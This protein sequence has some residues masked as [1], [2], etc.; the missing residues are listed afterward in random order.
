MALDLGTS[1]ACVMKIPACIS[2]TGKSRL[3]WCKTQCGGSEVLFVFRRSLSRE[4]PIPAVRV[5]K[6]R[7]IKNLEPGFD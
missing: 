1:Q 4:L 5:K 3:A 6:T 7:Q 2:G